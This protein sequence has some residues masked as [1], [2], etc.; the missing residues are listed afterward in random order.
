MKACRMK[1]HSFLCTALQAILLCLALLGAGGMG[2][3]AAEAPSLEGQIIEKSGLEGLYDS[4]DKGTQALLSQAGAEGIGAGGLDSSRL[5]QALGNL[6][7]DKLT[8]PLKAC[9]AFVAIAVLCKL[10]GCFGDEGPEG[11]AGMAGGLACA[12]VAVPAVWGAVSGCSVVAESASAFLLAAVPAYSALLAV[13]GGAA[14][15]GGYSFLTLGAGNLIPLLCTGLVLPLLRIF[16]ALAVSSCVSGTKLGKLTASL[17]SQAYR[18]LCY[19][20]RGRHTGGR[21]WGYPE[22]RRGGAVRGRGLWHAGSTVHLCPIYGRSGLVGGCLHH[23]PDSR[24]YMWSTRGECP[25][26]G[27]YFGGENG[28][29]GAG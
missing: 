9:A 26:G 1:Q 6:V 4:L 15:S 17:Y 3:S 22:Q 19:P 23:G 2:V 7:R 5:F 24:G 27:L 10:A 8:G 29:G 21:Y 20:Y 28:A 16:L 14:A 11:A 13:S 18:F 12:A 25:A